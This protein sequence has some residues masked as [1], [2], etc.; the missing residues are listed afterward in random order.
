[1]EPRYILA[2]VLLAAVLIVIAWL[3]TRKV[4][5]RRKFRIRQQGRGKSV[6]VNPAE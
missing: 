3:L 5:E 6:E 1:M 4:R 2:A